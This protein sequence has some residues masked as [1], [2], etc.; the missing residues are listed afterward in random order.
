MPLTAT[1]RCSY[2]YSTARNNKGIGYSTTLCTYQLVMMICRLTHR[3]TRSLFVGPI[4][5]SLE[6][7]G[8][9]IIREGLR[10]NNQKDDECHYIQEV[11]S[12]L[13]IAS[14]LLILLPLRILLLRYHHHHLTLLLMTVNFLKKLLSLF[15]FIFICCAHCFYFYFYFFEFIVQPFQLLHS[16]PALLILSTYTSRL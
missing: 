13:Q 11:V 8:Y 9:F 10:E 5:F 1:P 6:R 16:A 12:F 14:T 4:I 2:S 7:P 15:S 3:H